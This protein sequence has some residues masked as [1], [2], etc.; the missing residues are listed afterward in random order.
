[1]NA[2]H[3]ERG[4]TLIET[5]IVLC[6]LS[7]L[8]RVSLPAF[9]AVKRE[10]I[11]TRALADFNVVRSGAIAQYEATGSYPADAA[12]GAMPA[13]MKPYLPADFSFAR[14]DY[15]LDWDN[16]S[17]PDPANGTPGQV[18]AVTIT[19]HD[20][21]VGLQVLRTVGANCTHWSVDDSH[22]FVIFSTLE[23]R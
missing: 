2:R 5:M 17:V 1:M 21:R 4:F 9:D 7:I 20:S 3:I 15:E 18:L 14:K 8:V 13:G 16:F 11:A 23:A 19:A 6:V 12:P 22:T 10:A